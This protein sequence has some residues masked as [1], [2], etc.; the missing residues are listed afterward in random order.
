MA[1]AVVSGRIRSQTRRSWA[2]DAGVNAMRAQCRRVR[3]PLWHEPVFNPTVLA[4]MVPHS[5]T[6]KTEKPVV[7]FLAICGWR[8]PHDLQNELEGKTTPPVVT[9]SVQSNVVRALRADSWSRCCD[10]AGRCRGRALLAFGAHGVDRQ[11]AY[12]AVSVIPHRAPPLSHE[13]V[14]L[15]GIGL[16]SKATLQSYALGDNTREN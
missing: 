3:N 4:S 2:R 9:T 7:A 10:G 11:T 8:L 12:K 15:E 13:G 16:K 14:V 6:T 1:T 5:S